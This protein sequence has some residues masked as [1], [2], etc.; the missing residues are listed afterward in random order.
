MKQIID[1]PNYFIS[2]NGKVFSNKTGKLKELK[3]MQT[4][5]GYW[6]IDMM[7]NNKRVRKA[8][9]RLVC[10][11]YCEGYFEGAEVNHKDANTSN[12]H[13][14]NLEWCTSSY[15]KHQ[16]YITSG[17]NQTRNYNFYTIEYPNK[18][19]SEK[20]KG[21]KQ[22]MEYIDKNNLP[23]SKTSLQKYLF[24]NGYKLH[25]QLK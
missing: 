14:T 9:H 17:V 11:H 8:I 3:P 19:M 5:N 15:N 10:Y 1:F 21:Y 18:M 23:V 7:K 4:R 12:N 2:E 16:S 20:L 24:C 6:Y 13:Y 22:V 25:K